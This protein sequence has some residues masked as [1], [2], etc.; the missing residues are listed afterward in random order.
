MAL[1]GTVVHILTGTFTHGVHRTM[2]L[3]IGV[4]LGAQ[5]GAHFSQRVHGTW[6][7]RSLAL[8]L[9]LV[10]IRILMTVL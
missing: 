3:A 6:I 5:L 4:A 1:T 9:G 8:A 10:A 2:A 7:I